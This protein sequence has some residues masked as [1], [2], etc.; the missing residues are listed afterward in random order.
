MRT[1]GGYF[2]VMGICGIVPV[3]GQLLCLIG[4][5]GGKMMKH[6]SIRRHLDRMFDGYMDNIAEVEKTELDFYPIWVCWWQGEK[7]M[8][9]VP[10]ICLKRLRQNL[11]SDQRLIIISKD[12]YKDY[13]SLSQEAILAVEDGRVSITNFSDILRYALLSRYGGLWID[14]TCYT[15]DM[16]PDLTGVTLFT[17][18]DSSKANDNTFPSHYR[19]ASWLMGGTANRL[20][21]LEYRLFEAYVQQEIVFIDYLLLDYLLDYLYRHDQKCREIVDNCNDA[22]QYSLDMQQHLGDTY[23]DE[24]WKDLAGKEWAHKLSWKLHTPLMAADGEMTMFGKI[25][26]LLH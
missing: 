25:I 24:A 3:I 4:L 6:Y 5:G 13:V 8:P 9:L 22:C 23:E 1:L 20:F 2:K 16:L 21:T 19:W 18:K 15:T 11:R 14:S 10:K 17:S 7:R 26:D 12:N